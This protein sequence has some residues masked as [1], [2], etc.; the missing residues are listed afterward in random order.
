MKPNVKN[1]IGIIGGAFGII[2]GAIALIACII[3]A[4]YNVIFVGIVLMVVST[5]VLI[6]YIFL[7]RKEKTNNKSDE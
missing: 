3:R 4:N 1:F 7:Y 5:I 2:I 6:S